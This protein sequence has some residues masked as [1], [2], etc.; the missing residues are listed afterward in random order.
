MTE[1]CI[2]CGLFA[3]Q[4][5]KSDYYRLND[6]V[7]CSISCFNDNNSAP[8]ITEKSKVHTKSK[9]VVN[10]KQKT[11]RTIRKIKTRTKRSVSSKR[12]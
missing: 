8:K 9:K 11:K 2:E 6:S 3:G 1:R 7:F 12:R 4:E 10:G 5:Y